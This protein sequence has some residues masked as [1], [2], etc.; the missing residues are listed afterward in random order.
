M[1]NI[2]FFPFCSLT[3]NYAVFTRMS[4]KPKIMEN[5]NGNQKKRLK[6]TGLFILIFCGACGLSKH[7]DFAN[8]IIKRPLEA[9][10]DI[11]LK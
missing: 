6:L 1:C 5:K 10:N 3:L 9:K 8:L 4:K 11:W 2:G 7:I